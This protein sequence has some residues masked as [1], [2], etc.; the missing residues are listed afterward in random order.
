MR[1]ISSGPMV[2]GPYMDHLCKIIDPRWKVNKTEK[3]GK[4][5]MEWKK[6]KR[7]ERIKEFN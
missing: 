4:K 6:H 1:A 7:K 2:I 3:A 5:K